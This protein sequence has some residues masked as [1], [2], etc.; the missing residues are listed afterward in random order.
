MSR[1]TKLVEKFLYE[2]HNVDFGDIERLLDE[3]GYQLRKKAGSE[4]I[5]HKRGAQPIN[6][7]TVKGTKVKVRYVKRLVQL[8]ELEDWYE[9]HKDE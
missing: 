1:L 5:F 8:L 4:R 6:V 7:P 2:P 3:F 9:K